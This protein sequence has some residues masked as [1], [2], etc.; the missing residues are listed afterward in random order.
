MCKR[1]L[2][3]LALLTVR[4][5]VHPR[6]LDEW[7][8]TKRETIALLEGCARSIA[9]RVK[10]TRHRIKSSGAKDRSEVKLGQMH[11]PLLSKY[12]RNLLEQRMVTLQRRYLKKHG[13]PRNFKSLLKGLLKEAEQMDDIPRKRRIWRTTEEMTTA[14]QDKG[15]SSNFKSAEFVSTSEE[16][17]DEEA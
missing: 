12:T 9:T 3:V 16:D 15:D 4:R 6:E 2:R 11:I 1:L 10:L 7:D 13:E 14:K 17:E 8:W 5:S